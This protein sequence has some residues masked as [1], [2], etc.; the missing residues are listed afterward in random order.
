MSK[1]GSS[2]QYCG[3]EDKESGQTLHW[4][5]FAEKKLKESPIKDSRINGYR[6]APY[7]EQSP[8]PKGDN[9]YTY[10]II[11]YQKYSVAKVLGL[12]MILVQMTSDCQ[13]I[14]IVFGG[15]K[16]PA[17]HVVR[18]VLTVD[19]AATLAVYLGIKPP[20]GSAGVS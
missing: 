16:T 18:R 11:V 20:S 5:T 15:M 6:I 19:I 8:Q 4:T 10:F 3:K 13:V 1:I 12:I 7:E 14:Y 2:K 17:Q 9:W